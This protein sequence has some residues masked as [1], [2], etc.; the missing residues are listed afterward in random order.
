MEATVDPQS[1][2][3]ATASCPQTQNEYFIEGSQ[4]T[5]YCQLHGGQSAGES[6]PGPGC[7]AFS[8][9]ASLRRF[10]SGGIP[11]KSVGRT[12]AAANPRTRRKRGNRP[13]RKRAFLGKVFGIFGG[14]NKKPAD[15]SK[16]PQP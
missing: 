7:P 4:P 5:Q 9:K 10:R 12:E 2:Q 8:A 3:L 15:G 13:R 16:P 14:G 1:G 6:T 11:G